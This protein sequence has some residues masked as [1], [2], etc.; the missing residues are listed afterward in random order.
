VKEFHEVANIFPL[1][2]EAEF[3]SLKA[4]IAENGLREAVWLHPDGSIID[5]RNRY[6]ACTELGIVPE[7]R[8]WNGDG[9]LVSFV[10]SLNLHR[11]H[12]TE[13]QR[14]MVA[15]KLANMP[16]G[17]PNETTASIEAVVSQPEAAEL[18]SV[19]RSA[20]QRAKAVQETGT[21][22]LIAA[23]ERGQVSV[24]A[25]ADVATLPQEQ[26]AEIVAKGEKDILAAA[27]E[28]REKRGAIRR[29]E[30]VNRINEIALGN[31][32]L[33]GSM[34]RLFPV[35]YADP[36]WR[37][38]HSQT[39]NR[40]IE[41]H[42]PTMTLEEICALPVGDIVTPDSI[43]FLWTTSPKLEESM[44]VIAAWGFTYRTCLVWV[45][46]K[47]GMGYYARQRH[48]LLLVAKRGSIP[49]PDTD[50]R[51]DS[52]IECPRVEHSKKPDVVYEMID[53]MY[54]HFDKVELFARQTTDGWYT[55]GNQS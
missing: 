14:A 26:Q 32:P 11:R 5:G 31:Q 7:F 27:K 8:E 49:V 43:L 53:K 19:S 29:E 42:Y 10:V 20:V 28:I 2:T 47:I 48:E 45:K 37:Y 35:V 18:L 15:A 21:P 17:R 22:E 1:M 24:S 54:P 39:A 52:V 30:R 33:S 40:E 34:D 44:Q 3:S 50:A 16:E 4:D 12:L 9:S 36:P 23:V 41:N 6:N 38:E 13:S 46:D 51:F 25:A 55:W